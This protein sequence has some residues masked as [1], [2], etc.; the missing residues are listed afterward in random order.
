MNFTLRTTDLLTAPNDIT[1]SFSERLREAGGGDR[2]R[3][4]AC[5]SRSAA[6]L[7]ASPLVAMVM[8]R[9][10]MLVGIECVMTGACGVNASERDVFLRVA[11]YREGLHNKRDQL[12]LPVGA[13]RRYPLYQVISTAMTGY[14]RAVTEWAIVFGEQ[15]Y[16][17]PAE[18]DLGRRAGPIRNDLMMKKLE[19]HVV[20]AF[21]GGPGTA[22]CIKI[23]GEHSV[24]LI[25]EVVDP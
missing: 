10:R 14:D 3:I 20:V 6:L 23:A 24:P 1:A 4:V 18:W 12:R 9:I 13:R 22:S 7:D 15:W 16:A 2:V 19:P 17:E 11:G 8:N 5:G 21:P 25:I